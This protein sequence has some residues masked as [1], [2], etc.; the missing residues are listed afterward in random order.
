MAAQKG[1]DVLIKIAV[2]GSQVTVGGL[3]SSSIT[4]ND[5]MVDISTKDSSNN[6][7][8]LPQGGIQSMS[9]SG[10]GVFTDTN[11]EQQVRTNFGGASLSSMSFVIP[12]LGTYSG[13]FQITSLEFAGE[14]NGEATFSMTAES[15][16]A[17]SFAAA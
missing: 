13:S 16:G 9:I 8:L 7:E 17:I 15:S 2:S 12:D 11:S 6:R 14:Y 3:R 4:L 10:S 1:S 5:E